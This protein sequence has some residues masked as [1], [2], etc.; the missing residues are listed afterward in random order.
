MRGPRSRLAVYALALVIGA[1]GAQ[2]FGVPSPAPD[3]SCSRGVSAGYDPPP[4]HLGV[5]VAGR[6]AALAG[7][8]GAEADGARTGP[9]ALLRH[10]RARPVRVHRAHTLGAAARAIDLSSS[11]SRGLLGLVTSPANAPPGS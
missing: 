9:G 8:S 4:P 1:A 2:S 10:R 5:E 6:G 11:G 3:G 7:A